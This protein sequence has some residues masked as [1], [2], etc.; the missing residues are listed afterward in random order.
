MSEVPV[1]ER[2]LLL[3]GFIPAPLFLCKEALELTSHNLICLSPTAGNSAW[4][5]S[6]FSLEAAKCSSDISLRKTSYL[7]HIGPDENSQA[8]GSHTPATVPSSL[9]GPRRRSLC[10]RLSTSFLHP[11][12]QDQRRGAHHPSRRTFQELAEVKVVLHDHVRDH[13]LV[14]A[15]D[16]EQGGFQKNGFCII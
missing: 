1:R 7:K 13:L 16:L 8:G 15:D 6:P 11:H 10:S 12:W 5:A 9:P 3:R 4:L 2:D 14:E